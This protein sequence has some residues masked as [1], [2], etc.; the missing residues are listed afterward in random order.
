MTAHANPALSIALAHAKRLALAIDGVTGV[1]YG[2]C[3]KQGRAG[4]LRGIRFHVAKKVHK[5]AVSKGNLLPKQI[6][7][8]RC[9]V[10]QANYQPHGA[11]AANPRA[12]FDPIRPGTSVGNVQRITTG[13]L[14]AIVRDAAADRQSILGNWHVLCG[15]L[16][17]KS[18]EP[19]SQPGPFDAGSHPSRVIAHLSRWT[20]LSSG[21]DAAIAAIDPEVMFDPHELFSGIAPANISLPRL[22]QK[23]IK[24]GISTNLTHGVVDGIAGSFKMDYSPY[25]DTVRWMDGIHIVVDPDFHDPEVGLDGDSG[26]LWLEAETGNAVALHFGGED[27]LG[28]LADY[29]VG[30]SME[31]VCRTLN[32]QITNPPMPR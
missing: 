2:P 9:D 23:V 31:E 5:T 1:D 15:S 4:R 12:A 22:N 28:P 27:G 32:I 7:G 3:Q 16:D 21:I 13:T 20:N 17:C 11:G 18:G 30:H 24:S 14:G 8:F 29:A 25:G 10:V 26:A 6:H 19:L